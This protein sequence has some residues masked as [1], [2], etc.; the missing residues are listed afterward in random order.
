MAINNLCWIRRDLRLH[1]HQALSAA[2]KNGDSTYVIFIFDENILNKLSATNDKRI[3]FIMDSLIEIETVLN[4]YESSLIVCYGNPKKIILD[5]IDKLKI[6]NLCF[7]RDYE[8][9]AKNR[10]NDIITEAQKKGVAVHTFKDHVFYEKNEVQTDQQTTYKVFT[11][12]KN[13]WVSRFRAQ[14]SVVQNFKCNLKKLAKFENTK[15]IKKNDWFKEIGFIK[16]DLI[17]KGGTSQALLHFKQFEKYIDNYKLARDIPSLNQTSNLSTYIRMGNIS[18]RDMVRLSIKRSDEGHLTWLSELIWRDFYHTILD[19]Y[20]KVVTNCFKDEY[21]KILW[22]GTEK[23][24][25]L[26]CQGMTGYPIIDSAM[27]CLNATG[28]MHNRLRMITASFLVKTLLVDWKKGEKYFAEKL[29]DYDLAANNGG[30]QWSASTGVDAQPYFRIFNP[31]RQSEKFDKEG[32][33]IKTWCPEL[34][35]FTSKTIHSPQEAE[36]DEQVAAKCIIG[37][38]YPEPIV[39]YKEQKV[40]ALKIFSQIS[41]N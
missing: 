18:I 10:D 26:W 9:Y 35:A 29:L 2:L 28:M 20:P 36:L 4:D 5:I 12:Y 11:P 30:W 31:H 17:L 23:H 8:P 16:N 34:I 25:E 19:A 38:N 39:Y 41:K 1:D 15:S 32:L 6:N 21:N 3:T 40:K 13:K 33:F 37:I 22:P 24:F 14:E 27:R 7:N